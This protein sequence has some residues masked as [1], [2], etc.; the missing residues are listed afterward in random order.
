MNNDQNF[1]SLAFYRLEYS[2]DQ[3]KFWLRQNGMDCFVFNPFFPGTEDPARPIYLC[4]FARDAEGNYL[5]PYTPDLLAPY[6]NQ[7]LQLSGPLKLTANLVWA[8]D[9]QNLLK[10]SNPDDNFLLFTPA[11]DAHGQVYYQIQPFQH[12][13]SG[14]VLDNSSID[15]NPSPPATSMVAE[16]AD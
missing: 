3:V 5:N 4:C 12:T 8:D 1:Q 14:D 10:D 16:Q 9:M 11:V 7:V 6:P 15:T 2:I 13:A